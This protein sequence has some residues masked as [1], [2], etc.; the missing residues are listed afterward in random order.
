MWKVIHIIVIWIRNGLDIQVW[1][2]LY[3][4][5]C[6]N[7]E[8]SPPLF[9]ECYSRL[10]Q[11]KCLSFLRFIPHYI[12]LTLDHSILKVNMAIEKW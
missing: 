12:N 6:D 4:L 3:L 8:T 11:L 5:I 1:T 2:P 9:N 7:A 10:Y